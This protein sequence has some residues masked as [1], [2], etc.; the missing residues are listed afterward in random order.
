LS[1]FTDIATNDKLIVYDTSATSNKTCT[2]LSLLKDYKAYARVVSPSGTPTITGDNVASITDNGSG[3]ITVNFT[4]AMSSSTYTVIPANSRRNS[5]S[6]SPEPPSIQ[7]DT[8]TYSTTQ[9]KIFTYRQDTDAA[10]S[11]SEFCVYV[12]EN[13]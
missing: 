12:M 3:S 8:S 9:F 10:T 1:E 7:I 5:D 11:I 6:G 13:S 2:T 4:T